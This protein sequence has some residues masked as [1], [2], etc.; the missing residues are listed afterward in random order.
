[1]GAKRKREIKHLAILQNEFA[2]LKR[3]IIPTPATLLSIGQV[4]HQLRSSGQLEPV[5]PKHYNDIT[6][7]CLARQIGAT[8]IT[9]NT[10]DF[11]IIQSV[12][13]FE[14]EQP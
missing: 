14:F 8:V 9:R 10:H 1:M 2:K 5:H 11:S 7:A 6:I 13:D 4:C 3:L 12:I